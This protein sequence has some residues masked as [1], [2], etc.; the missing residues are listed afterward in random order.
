[1]NGA[2]FA[3]PIEA[4]L[5]VPRP[6][7]KL[8][9]LL[10]DTLAVVPMEGIEESVNGILTVRTQQG[11]NLRIGKVIAA[12]PGAFFPAAAGLMVKEMS[13]HVGDIVIYRSWAS[14]DEMDRIRLGGEAFDLINESDVLTKCYYSAIETL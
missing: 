12:G 8:G 10:G 6:T 9:E 3:V 14:G 7:L 5:D 11:R 4:V 1:V 13:V 2:K